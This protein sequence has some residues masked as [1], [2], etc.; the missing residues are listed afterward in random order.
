MKTLALFIGLITISFIGKASDV[1]LNST[2]TYSSTSPPSCG[3][4]TTSWSVSGC[5]VIS[6]TSSTI[7]VQ[8]TTLGAGYVRRTFTATCSWGPVSGT[9]LDEN[10]TVTNTAPTPATPV[11]QSNNCSA[12]TFAFSGTPP[13]GI[14]WYWQTSATGTVMTN[15]ASTYTVNDGNTYYLYWKS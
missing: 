2:A 13:T 12:A 9:L 15:S 3:S 10:V 11:V 7:T 8:W 6:Q 4:V 5:T 1:C 14:T